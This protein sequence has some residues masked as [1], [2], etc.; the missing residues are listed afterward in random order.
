MAN[1]ILPNFPGGYNPNFRKKSDIFWSFFLFINIISW[2][3]LILLFFDRFLLFACFLFWAVFSLS[4]G[5]R[6]VVKRGKTGGR[7]CSRSGP[8]GLS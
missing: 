5:G 4:G 2:M 1:T 3:L 6:G 7:G 8:T